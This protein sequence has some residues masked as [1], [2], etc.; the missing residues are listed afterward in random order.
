MS[1]NDEAIIKRLTELYNSTDQDVKKLPLDSDTKYALFSDLHFGDGKKADN[2]VHNEKTLECALKFYK[3]KKYSIIFLGDLE[4][5]WQFDLSIIKSRYYKRIYKL[6]RSFPKETI[7]RIFGNHDR[8]WKRPPDPILNEV[9]IQDGTPEAIKLGKDIFLVHGHQGD[10]LC[11]KVI[12]FSKFWSR[13]AKPLVFILKMFGYENR[14]ATKSQI[15]KSRERVYYNWAKKN[16]V[17]LI[18]GHTH[19]AIF[20]SR[21]YYWWLKENIKKKEIE[22]EKCSNN[23]VQQKGLSGEIRKLKR[24]LRYE[25]RKGRNYHR[26]VNK[27]IPLPCYFNTGCGLYSKGITNIEIEGDK[28]RLIKWQSD[29]SILEE[30]QRKELWDEESLSVLRK[31]IKDKS[32]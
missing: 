32:I 11:D 9:H 27:G 31:K 4:E 19:N 20:A 1:K 8:E 12:W 13:A 2:F 25:K 24:K 30:A 17:F 3:N 16:K 22:R 5:L 6:L 28:I 26:V 18:C 7:H 15:P 29:E 14:S 10:Y 23:K 21:S